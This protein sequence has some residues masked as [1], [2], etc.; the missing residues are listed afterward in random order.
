[1]YISNMNNSGRSVNPDMEDMP[2]VEPLMENETA[3]ALVLPPWGP[4]SGN[5]GSDSSGTLPP[6]GPPSGNG[7]SSGTLPPWGPPSNNPGQIQVFPPIIL[8]G[9]P[10][11]YPNANGACNIRFLYAAVGGRPVNIRIGNRTIISNF[12]YSDYTP[13]YTQAA[14]NKTITLTSTSN[15]FGA[16]FWGNFYFQSGYAY[17]DRKSVV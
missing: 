16:Y 4:P 13:Y 14:G 1:M 3:E 5:G 17:T 11:P 10:I 2:A 9:F 7:G 8:P 15:P 12:K 6:W